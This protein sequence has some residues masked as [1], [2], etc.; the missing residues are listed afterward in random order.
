MDAIAHVLEIPRAGVWT[1]P[2]VAGLLLFVTVARAVAYRRRREPEARKSLRRVVTWCAL[3]ALL[4]GVLALGRGVMILVMLGISLL[5]LREA[6]YLTGAPHLYPWGMVLT[7]TLYG[8]AWLDW[9]SLFLYGLPSC[10][11]LLAVA[12]LVRRRGGGAPDAGAWRAIAPALPLAVIGPSYTIG[13]ASLPAHATLPEGRF[14][15][16]VLLLLLT[17]VHDSAQAWWGRMFGSRQL[18]PRLSPAKTWEGLWGGLVTTAFVAALAGPALTPLGRGALPGAASVVPT[19]L[20]SAAFG[21]VVAVAGTAGDLAA[22]ALKRRAGVKDSGAVVP[23]HGGVLDRFDSLAA[24]A[25][26]FFFLV[27]FVWYRP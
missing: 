27:L 2:A 25:P 13:A 14:G 4:L 22:S 23:G 19:W 3:F 7:I 18:A 12:E 24:T 15:W 21:L 5:G 9:P 16:L 26:V 8:W 10:V 11:A 1:L 6:L 17:G 20:Y